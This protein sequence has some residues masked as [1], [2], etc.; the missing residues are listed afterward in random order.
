MRAYVL[1]AIFV[2]LFANTA[3]AETW[4]AQAVRIDAKSVTSRCGSI[5]ALYTFERNDNQLT[6]STNVEKFFTITLPAAAEA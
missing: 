4:Q 1:S 2:A 6:A 3:D 5:G